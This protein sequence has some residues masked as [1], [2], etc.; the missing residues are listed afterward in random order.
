MTSTCGRAADRGKGAGRRA[1]APGAGPPTRIVDGMDGVSLLVGAA[2][3]SAAAWLVASQRRRAEAA[4]AAMGA[5]EAVATAQAT[6][7]AEGE[8]RADA[9]ARAAAAT[10]EAGDL[11]GRLGAA[12]ERVES[13]RLLLVEQQAFVEKSRRDL[14]ATFQALAA[15]ALQGSSEQFLKLAEQRLA[16]TRSQ[17]AAD[18][19]E[20]KRSIEALVVPLKETLGKL[21]SRTA[22]IETARAGAYAKIDEQVST[23]FQATESLRR[24]TTTL[25]TALKSSQVRGRWGEM[26]LR[27]VVEIAG[28]TEH[29]DFE[30]QQTIGDPNSGAGRRPDLVVRLPGWRRIA[31]DAKAPLDAYLDACGQAAEPGR[32]DALKRH[33][34]CLR[35]H[36]QALASKE[37]WALLGG[38]VDLVVLFLPG[39]PFLAAA[40]EREPDLQVDALRQRILVA[41][42]TTLVALLR[43]IAIYHQQESLAINAQRIA[44]TARE[45]YERGAKFGEDLARMRKGLTTAID[46]FN[47]AVGSFEGRFLP[48]GRKLEEFK[49]ASGA[50][51]RLESPAPLEEAPRL[52]H[53]VLGAG[54]AG[55]D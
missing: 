41:T 8:R 17:A 23:L 54:G 36:V 22:E 44:E 35:Q 13:T 27:N 11:R 5:A 48:M 37:Y 10:A 21:E 24:E 29:C 20:R 53:A 19:E 34:A 39:E 55:G 42:P 3:G 51:R 16:T 49:A 52:V 38:G 25:S 50:S 45:L 4:R 12:A 6:A 28:M 33:A 2:L 43:T 7:H 40:F 32:T 47:S 18:L 31:V 30:E 1:G 14:E 26:A 46:A 15:S 9:E